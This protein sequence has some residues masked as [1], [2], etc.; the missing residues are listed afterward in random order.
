MLNSA[1]FDARLT[2]SFT[3]GRQPIIV[4]QRKSRFAVEH[5]VRVKNRNSG[6]VEVSSEESHVGNLVGFHM[7]DQLVVAILFAVEYKPLLKQL[8]LVDEK[9]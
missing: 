2:V 7:P 3:S 9:H 5:L 4:E 8:Q 6:V 1:R